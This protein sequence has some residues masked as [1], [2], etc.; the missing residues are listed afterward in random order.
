[1]SDQA[2]LSDGRLACSEFARQASD[3]AIAIALSQR[4]LTL[5]QSYVV[6]EFATQ[7]LCPKQLPATR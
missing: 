3:G 2:T 7:Y 4:H 6:G 5:F 1:M